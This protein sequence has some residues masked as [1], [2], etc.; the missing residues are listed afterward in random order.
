MAGLFGV[1]HR[2]GG[3]E[4]AG[5]VMADTAAGELGEGRLL[6]GANGF[7]IGAAGAKAAAAWDV[8]W[9]RHIAFDFLSGDSDAV[10]ARDSGEQ[11]AGVRVARVVVERVGG[12]QLNNL[13]EIHD[14]DPVGNRPHCAE[15]VGDKQERDI[16]FGLQTPE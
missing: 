5:G 16:R 10:K 14:G 8:Y 3:S 1:Q 15:I 11:G 12:G 13:A 4:V 7:S 2:Q 9:G 6:L